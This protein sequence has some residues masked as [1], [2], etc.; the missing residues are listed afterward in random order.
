MAEFHLY[1]LLDF[2]YTLKSISLYQTLSELELVNYVTY[3]LLCEVCASQMSSRCL[4]KSKKKKKNKKCK[5]FISVS[6]R[7]QENVCLCQPD[8]L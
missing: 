4:N 2:K 5:K 8:M 3:V 7:W 1:S 6:K